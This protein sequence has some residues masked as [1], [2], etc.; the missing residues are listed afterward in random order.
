[1]YGPEGRHR[2]SIRLRGYDYAW[3]GMY[4]VTVCTHLKRCLLGDVVNGGMILS[5]TGEI[6]EAG[7][8]GLPERFPCVK[9]DSHVVMPNHVHVILAFRGSR[10][11][12][13]PPTLG[14][15]VRH[16]KAASCH[17]IRAN[18][19]PCFGW[20]RNYYERI[21]RNENETDRVR[22]Y[23]AENPAQW[24]HDTENPTLSP[25]L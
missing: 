1:M 20:Q 16:W 15:I 12:E 17:L 4:F 8:L 24:D 3:M 23:I 10:S 25:R 21:L 19:D 5:P 22:R 18:V 11:D 7:L 6:V 14:S 13:P 9:V 2:R